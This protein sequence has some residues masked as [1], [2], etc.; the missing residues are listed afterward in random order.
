VAL[1]KQ[2]VNAD[3]CTITI[4][5]AK[6]KCGQK[7]KLR[8]IKV[9]EDLMIRLVKQMAEIPGDFIFEPNGNL[10]GLFDRIINRA[11]IPK[12][13]PLGHKLTAHSFRHTFATLQA[14]AVSFNPFLLK[15]I[16]GHCQLS[17][18]DRYCH[19]RTDAVIIEVSNLLGGVSEEKTEDD[20]TGSTHD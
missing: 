11:E 1:L 16:L 7:E 8:I 2:E 3:D 6:L 4:R 9:P 12:I 18:T 15:E 5:T 13:D 20:P 14:S 10:S 19:A 17:T